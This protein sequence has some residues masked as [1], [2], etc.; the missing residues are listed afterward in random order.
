[1]S[2]YQQHFLNKTKNN[3]SKAEKYTEGIVQSQRRNIEQISEDTG[4]DYHQIA[5]NFL[6]SSFILKEKIRSFDDLPLLSARD[7]KE[8]LVNQLYN[9][10]S[11]DQ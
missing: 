3:F 2:D 1:M 7:I 10:M 5:L 11:Q 4:A 8:M 9:Q 6:V